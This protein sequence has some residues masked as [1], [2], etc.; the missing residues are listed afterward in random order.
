MK[1]FCICIRYFSEKKGKIVNDFV[2]IFIVEEANG[3]NL[4]KSFKDY[5]KNIGLKMSNML[6]IG[7]DGGC[8][9]CSKNKSL[10][11]HLRKDIPKL[12]LIK[13]TC[14]SL[15]LCCS[16][17]SKVILSTAEFIVKELY[18]Y[19][20]KSSLRNVEYM[21]AFEL[22]NTGNDSIRYRK[23]VQLSNTR[24]LAYAGAVRRIL[25]QWIELNITFKSLVLK[26]KT[27]WVKCYIRK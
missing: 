22:I 21:R 11:A 18:G 12:I 26:K 9:L 16:K 23:L 14:Y 19:F 5:I 3:E 10:F 7:T 27:I 13:C 4:Y 2:G 20:S 25:E 1:W 15:H 17:A 8:N 6:A 24:W